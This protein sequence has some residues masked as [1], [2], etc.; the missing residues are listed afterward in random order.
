[1]INLTSYFAVTHAIFSNLN[2]ANFSV[3]EFVA[4]VNELVAMTPA[5][6]LR[7]D[8]PIA[9]PGIMTV[10][11]MNAQKRFEFVFLIVFLLFLFSIPVV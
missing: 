5:E 9:A 11:Y 10:L 4:T 6:S 3:A 7:S 1:M 2:L 8:R